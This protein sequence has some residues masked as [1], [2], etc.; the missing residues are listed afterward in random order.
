[1]AFSGSVKAPLRIPYELAIKDEVTIKA[2]LL[3]QGR[4]ARGET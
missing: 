2:N 1:M 3:R 4:Q